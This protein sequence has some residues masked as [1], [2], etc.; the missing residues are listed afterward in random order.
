MPG[1]NKIICGSRSFY[2]VKFLA[3][4]LPRIMSL[5]TQDE[6][7]QVDELIKRIMQVEGE[8]HEELHGGIKIGAADK[9]VSVEKHLVK[10]YKKEIEQLY[11][12]DEDS[13]KVE[14]EEINHLNLIGKSLD[15]VMQKLKDPAK[16]RGCR[17]ALYDFNKEQVRLNMII[18]SMGDSQKTMWVRQGNL[19]QKSIKNFSVATATDKVRGLGTQMVLFGRQIRKQT[20]VFTQAAREIE[21]FDKELEAS[22]DNPEKVKD[23]LGSITKSMSKFE[24]F[25]NDLFNATIGMRIATLYLLMI[26]LQHEEEDVKAL[27]AL[28]GTGFSKA[29]HDAIIVEYNKLDKEEKSIEQKEMWLEEEAYRLVQDILALEQR[30]LEDE[31]IDL[32]LAT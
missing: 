2:R 6:R 3:N 31:E 18:G 11:I 29:K 22:L 27:D 23:I 15:S 7:V 14:G 21:H 12:I 30:L 32:K 25:L 28:L 4:F 13:L 1:E 26:V 9:V 20:P 19:V 16:L 5:V 8:L 24:E 17:H 10:L